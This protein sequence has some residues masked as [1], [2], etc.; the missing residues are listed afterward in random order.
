MKLPLL[1]LCC[2]IA[3]TSAAVKH[4]RTFPKDFIFGTSTAAYQIEGA[5]NSDDKS[6]NIWDYLTH[7]NPGAIDDRSTGDV[8][9]DSFNNYKRD[10]E[11]MREL[12]IDSYRF[13][14]AWSR[15]LPNGLADRV[16]EA[17]IAYYNN[18]I[19]EVLKYNIQPMITLYHWDL[20]QKLQDMGGFLNPLIVDWFA[21]Y[22]R[23][24]FDNFGDRVKTFITFNEAAQVCYEG[25]GSVTKAPLLNLTGIGEYICAKNLVLAHA[26]AY[27]IYNNEFR[28]KQGGQC[29]YTIA[30]G[31][32]LPLTD[33][34]EDRHAV[35]LFIQFQWALYTDPIFS[36][37]GGFPKE[38]TELA[39]KKSAAQGYPRSRLPDFTEEEKAY[40]RGTSDF[41][42]V[43]HY[44]GAL[45]SGSLYTNQYAVPS[46]MDDIEVGQVALDDWLQGASPWL[47]KMPSSLYHALRQ[48]NE[49]YPDYPI[50]VT[51]NGWSTREGIEDDERVDYYRDALEDVLD[52][53]DEGIDVRGYYAW[54][55][56]DNFEWLAGYTERFGLY[57]VDFE[58]PARTRTPRKSAFIYKQIMKTRMIDHDYEP[59]SYVMTIDPGH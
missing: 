12:G 21:D 32:S 52:A 13:S 29:G 49:R 45:T 2:T 48:I 16:S 15:I 42:G 25:Y 47:K 4:S 57:E 33:S 35:E 19:D 59:E 14:V 11:M 54:S 53:L 30:A 5:W 20:P 55:L 31:A 28:D 34:D 38:L 40:V 51:E 9:C 50:I 1:F 46:S 39:A 23:V 3:L 44:S 8:A 24:V 43:N 10:V 26:N 58:D 6:E 7:T 37:D 22:A 36:K 56:M 18:V 27:H 41:F 17:G